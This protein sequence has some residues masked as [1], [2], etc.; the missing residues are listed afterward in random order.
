MNNFFQLDVFEY[1]HNY[2]FIYSH[3][4]KVM[5]LVINSFYGSIQ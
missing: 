5:D 1:V 2:E 4:S 3:I